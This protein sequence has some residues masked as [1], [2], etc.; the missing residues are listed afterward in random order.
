MV[1]VA[2]MSGQALGQTT[3]GQ[4]SAVITSDTT[5]TLAGS[6]YLLTRDVEVRPQATLTI[7]AG[8]EV[9]FGPTDASATG[10]PNGVELLVKGRLLVNG[11]AEASVNFNGQDLAGPAD[12]ATGVRFAEG[13]LGSTL[14]YLSISGLAYG[15]DQIGDM[16]LSI[17]G[18]AIDA[19]H[20]AF[21]RSTGGSDLIFSGA[22]LIGGDYSLDLGAIDED[23]FIHVIGST[24]E[25]PVR[26]RSEGA[27]SISFGSELKIQETDI[28]GSV[29]VEGNLLASAELNVISSTISNGRLHLG[30]DVN[31]GARISIEQSVISSPQLTPTF[32]VD[33]SLL[34]DSVVTIS[35]STLNGSVQLGSAPEMNGEGEGQFF[36]IDTPATWND[37]AAGC[38]ARGGK[39][40]DASDLNETRSIFSAARQSSTGLVW[41]G[42][43]LANADCSPGADFVALD[44][45][46]TC[47]DFQD[48]GVPVKN[49]ARGYNCA[50]N[51]NCGLQE[52][53]RNDCTRTGFSCNDTVDYLARLPE[54]DAASAEVDYCYGDRFTWSWEDGTSL[55]QTAATWGLGEADRLTCF[56]GSP[57]LTDT[58]HIAVDTADATGGIGGELGLWRAKGA[59]ATYSYVCEGR[60]AVPNAQEIGRGNL[61]ISMTTIDGALNARLGRVDMSS[62]HVTK[63]TSLSLFREAVI[64]RSMFNGTV[65]IASRGQVEVSASQITLVNLPNGTNA[66]GGLQVE[67]AHAT[68]YG[69]QVDEGTYGVSIRGTGEIANNLITRTSTGIRV[70]PENSLNIGLETQIA[71]NT[72]VDN[73]VGLMVEGTID[74]PTTY[75]HN[76]NVV[77]GNSVGM[78]RVGSAAIVPNHNNIFA[79]DNLYDG[80]APDA[81]SVTANPGFVADYPAATPIFRL[82]SGSPLIDL[83][84]CDLA[85]NATAS[86]GGLRVDIDGIPRPFDGDFDGDA[87][88]DIGAYEFG[89]EEIFMYADGVTATE[90]SFATGIEVSLTLW[91]RR[92]AN[93]FPVSPAVWTIDPSVGIFNEDTDQF[94]PS[95]TPG[96]YAGALHAQ[97]GNLTTSLDV[98][99]SCGCQA[100]DEVNGAQGECNGVPACYFSDWAC[101]VRENYCQLAEI[102]SFENPLTIAA[103]ESKQVRPGGRDIYGF[104]FKYDGP[105]IYEVIN[106]GGSIDGNGL[107]TATSAAGDYV[108]SLRIIA[109][110]VS[111]VSDVK[112][113]P[114]APS[115]IVIS[116]AS[117]T[118]STTR[119]LLYTAVVKDAFNNIIPDVQVSWSIG[120]A[121]GATIDPVTG[122]V[123]AGC[124][125]GEFNDVVTASF[126]GVSQ[127]A[128]LVVEQ[129]G[130]ILTDIYL[131]S[132]TN[133]VPATTELNF[134]V[135]VED[136][137]GFIRPAIQPT[138]SVSGSAGSVDQTG[139]FTAGC[140]LG[141]F[142]S[143]VLVESEGLSTSATLNITS[144]PLEV[145]TLEPSNAQIRMG[146]TLDFEAVGRDAC[147]RPKVIEPSWSTSVT[148]GGTSGE[149]L[150][151]NRRRLIVPCSTEGFV[152]NGISAEYV[153]E[154]NR[155]FVATADIDVL[156]GEVATL[157]LPELNISL[158]A[159]NEIQLQANAED[160]CG[161][162]RNDAIR[163][164]ASNGSV[165][166]NTGLY[167]AGCD[168]GDFPNA[169]FAQAGTQTGQISVEVTDGVLNSID[170]I[171]SPVTTQAGSQRQLT[172]QLFDGCGNIINREPTWRSAEGGTLTPTGLLTASE[173]ARTY[174][175]AII[176]ELDGI[177]QTA[178]LIVTPS[179]AT[180]LE[181]SPDP[182]IVRAGSTTAV[183]V[184][185]FDEFGNSFTP[186]V[187]WTVSPNAG[188]IND[189]NEFTA[190]TAVGVITEGIIARVGEA[191][192]TVEVEVVASDVA[193]L[194][195]Q[196]SPVMVSANASVQLTATPV[197]Q[198]GN[199]VAGTPITWSVEAGG[200]Q[201][202]AAGLFTA[203]AQAGTYVDSLVA[204]GGGVT[205]RVTIN[206]MPSE[207]TRL[208]ITPNPIRVTPQEER[209]LILEVFD[210]DLN[211]IN[212]SDVVYAVASGGQHFTVSPTGLLR[213]LEV[214]GQGTLQV[215]ANGLSETIDVHVDAG[216]V[217]QIEVRRPEQNELV[218]VQDTLV[219]TPGQV[220]ELSAI[221]MDA[222]ENHVD[223][224][225]VW[226]T[227]IEGFGVTNAGIF[228]AGQ[229]AGD[230]PSAIRVRYLGVNRLINVSV[231]PGPAVAIHINPSVVVVSPGTQVQ[232]DAYFSD[233]QGNRIDIESNVEWS[234]NV[235]SSNLV[236]DSSG[237]LE[238]PCRV[239]PGYYGDVV[240]VSAIPDGSAT[241]LNGIADVEV[242]SGETTSVAFEQDRLEVTVT[243]RVR[244]A[245][246]GTDL[247]GYRTNDVPRYSV[248]S[249]SGSIGADGNYTAGTVTGEVIVEASIDTETSQA[250][251]IVTPGPAVALH[252]DPEDI[253]VT[254]GE[255]QEFTVQAE[256]EFGN[257]WT[258]S[259]PTWE[260]VTP[261][262]GE[263]AVGTVD[264]QGD[265]R[266]NTVAGRYDD[267]LKVSFQNQEAFASIILTPDSPDQ[268]VITPAEP[269]LV[270]NQSLAF[271]ALI[272]D[273]YGNEI[274]DVE[275]TFEV[276]LSEAGSITERGVFTASTQVGDYDGAVSAYVLIEGVATART[277]ATIH[278]VN[279]TPASVQIAPDSVTLPVD[280]RQTFEA[281]VLDDEGVVIEDATVTWSL[282]DGDIGTVMAEPN[283]DGRLVVG[284][285]PGRYFSGIIATVSIDGVELIGTADVII[286]RDFDN[287]GI[288]DVLELEVGLKPTDDEDAAAD[289]DEDGLTN[290]EEVAVGL[291]HT[292]AD[293]DDDGIIDGDEAGWGID[294]DRDGLV[295]GLDNDS[296]GDGI[297]DG[298]EAGITQPTQDT[299][300]SGFTPD[301]DPQ[302]V[303]DPLLMD[304]DSD[305]INDGDEDLNQ[306]GR[307]DPGETPANRELNVI[308]CDP[309]LEVTGCPA[310]LICLENVCADPLP[311]PEPE[312]DEGCD[313]QGGRSTAW[314]FFLCL[315]ILAITR[316]RRQL[317]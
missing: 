10:D 101:P 231:V 205:Q 230:Y 79:Y 182:F 44:D 89:P 192:T 308:A 287:D 68:V 52:A 298:V 88:C 34:S 251:A 15:V 123:T 268:I 241:P 76:N 2:A 125:S 118:V 304:S 275:A 105:F 49:I 186:E 75:I 55:D 180:T 143:A 120:A 110:G 159:G 196:P 285:T 129:G 69:N 193:A 271:N 48:L 235:P 127:T 252:V 270:P 238:A 310:D 206:V 62:S 170:I 185:A 98:D 77:R 83:G 253:D 37:A 38:A 78:R 184:T 228:T 316:R 194:N 106:G 290:A 149:G 288:E 102:G 138:F 257:L 82:D 157:T 63:E 259:T 269:T 113:V 42:G 99:L 281:T 132:E 276:N 3:I 280:G 47:R 246:Y 213:G 234:I 244:F 130:A 66:G 90:N 103:E 291:D 96:F 262:E 80:F 95:A 4:E 204:S 108:G 25:G 293:S 87:G 207:A 20:V 305:G 16:S 284:S 93:I 263:E 314:A 148:N 23:V 260:V 146:T 24:L 72:L 57:N 12:H 169:I 166:P 226:S 58:L 158:P 313:A 195:I 199:S 7:E 315:S 210:A 153:D 61:S 155:P 249:G 35:E 144:A 60:L 303:T 131:I 302:T 39:L 273:I 208:V 154:Y 274:R 1:A 100:P 36:L 46:Q 272:Q 286:P 134:S 175:G 178:D 59:D 163:W 8:V 126:G 279:S 147:G 190:A 214:S 167:T 54:C 81:N 211:P 27:G 258:P 151:V 18:L 64:N 156:P 264:Q 97:F 41:I 30:G 104:V 187:G 84:R 45:V 191:E 128:D 32:Q 218:I 165:Q 145:L 183:T 14:H 242:I 111:G 139:L 51:L 137:C 65:N 172:A 247:C 256:D 119:T 17:M 114:N 43:T 71:N 56:G 19:T 294:T 177:Q 278:I 117:E 162:S 133:D 161:N 225:L 142:N 317:A 295:N 107:F 53:E 283:G 201:V 116:K 181:V 92:D 179:T 26:L 307:L 13:A 67:S 254:V 50:C 219:V 121:G 173:D 202:D 212:P 232:L 248:I 227:S 197:D 188:E 73:D 174:F 91:G 168:R 300:S 176:A 33:G 136:A 9:R 22:T 217:T 189:D 150:G 215:N 21:Q 124:A 141:L 11:T 135:N 267:S 164:S 299:A 296:D 306:N 5:W 309:S 221:A 265:L 236:V 94:R 223:V 160:A 237:Q 200:G 6:P 74:A 297:P 216:P 220:V 301:A 203:G 240:S 277:N 31:T 29:T 239:S 109:D 282:S 245:A 266:A 292:D 243:G 86:E 224:P 250:T 28:Q 311:E 152:F 261:D 112:V 233:I 85:P 171:P 222:F 229:V 209:Q 255:R 140:Q 198:F 312:P 122:R 70:I 40:A 115:V 289:D